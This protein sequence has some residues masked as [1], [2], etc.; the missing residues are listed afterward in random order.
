M[1]FLADLLPQVR[2]QV[3]DPT[4]L[5]GLPETPVRRA[6]S[7]RDAVSGAHDG[8]AILVERK[9][10]SPGAS[11]STLPEISLDQFVK[12]A[13][14]GRADGLSCLATAPSFRGSPQEVAQL[15]R[16]SGLP[17]LFK[18]FVVDPIQ[19][20]AAYRSGASAILLIARL[21]TGGFLELPIRELAMT[22]RARGLEVL[23][24][25][26][27]EDEWPVAEGVAVDLFGV[28]LRD[29]DT[30][31]FQPDTAEAT[32]RAAGSRHPLLGLSGVSAPAE[33]DRYRGWGADGLLVGTGFARASDPG[34][35]LRAL[36]VPRRG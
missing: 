36:R 14:G 28:N 3:E 17:V 22:A 24:E 23:L 7:L 31:R 26:H 30:L 25:V 21:E 6:P 1:G 27:G 33:A 18:D 35:F 9:H 10:E 4:Y 13:Q 29:L 5:E 11:Q 32:F 8:W 19:V 2:A 12:W 34:A 15:V 20:E 16:V